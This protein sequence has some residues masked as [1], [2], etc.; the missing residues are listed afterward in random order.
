MCPKPVFGLTG[1]ALFQ[2]A[3]ISFGNLVVFCGFRVDEGEHVVR[4]LHDDC[5][6]V[7]ERVSLGPSATRLVILMADWEDGYTCRVVLRG[8]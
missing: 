3:S 8:G 6:G 7:P 5:E 4:V 1:N 2:K